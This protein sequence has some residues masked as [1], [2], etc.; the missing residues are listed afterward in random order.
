VA[1]G[2]GYACCGCDCAARW[3]LV[4][5]ADVRAVLVTVIASKH[6]STLIAI[7]A[8]RH[9]RQE[10]QADTLADTESS[11]ENVNCAG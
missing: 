11:A 2:V 7:A 3:L 4:G 1:G 5:V 8:A 6:Y 10:A 9:R